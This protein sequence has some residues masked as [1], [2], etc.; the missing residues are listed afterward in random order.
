MSRMTDYDSILRRDRLSPASVLRRQNRRLR[1]LVEHAYLHVPYYRT[2]MDN[3]GL[4]PAD[5]RGTADLAGFPM[6]SKKDIK[7]A[8]APDLVSDAVRADR[9]PEFKTTGSTGV[10]LVVRRSK[11]EDLLFH[12]FRMRA[13]RSYGLR[14]RDPVVRI[15]SGNLDYIPLS[16]RLARAFRLYRQSVID[17]RDTPQENAARLLALRPDVLTGYNSSLARIAR[18]IACDHGTVL[19]LRLVVGGADMLTPLLRRQIETAFQTRTYDNYECVEVG[20]MAWE[21]PASGLYHVCDDNVI[22]EVLDNDGRPAREGEAGEV[23]VTSLHLRTMPFIRYRLEDIVTVGPPACPCG[24]PYRTLRTIEAKK[25]DYFRLPGGQEFYP[26]AISLYLV[27]NAPWVLQVE[28]VQE[29]LDRVVM[30][31]EAVAPPP[32]DALA[33]LREGIRPML[34]PNVE[35]EISIVPELAPTPGG[36]FWIRRSLVNSLYEDDGEMSPG[37]RRTP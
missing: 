11:A 25:Q 23:V 10:P 20:L 34:G 4:A 31:A 15:R 27:D 37:T 30:R 5:V 14:A 2:L 18:I 6:T 28:L 24:L 7:R 29:R 13:I 36:K 9:L 33:R 8:A 17:T 21:C 3:A 35:F 26:W 12:L 16:W 32:A 19:P 22:L 1:R